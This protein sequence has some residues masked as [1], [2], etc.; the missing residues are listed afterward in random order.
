[1]RR[2]V[3]FNKK[4]HFFSPGPDV[5]L[6]NQEIEQIEQDGWKVLSVTANCDFLGNIGSF[7]ILIES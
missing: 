4:K 6:L 5:E 1:M 3:I 7:T 2:V